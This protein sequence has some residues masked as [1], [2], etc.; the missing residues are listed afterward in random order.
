[1]G[2]YAVA[3]RKAYAESPKAEMKPLRKKYH[4]ALTTIEDSQGKG[5]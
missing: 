3:Y 2:S 4:A 1:M 5:D